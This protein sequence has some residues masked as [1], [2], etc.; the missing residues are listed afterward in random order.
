M[1]IYDFD[2]TIYR[3]DSTKDFYFHCLKRYPKILLSVPAMAWAFVLY[4]IGLKT[5][6]QFKE[7]MYRFLTYIDDVEAEVESFWDSHQDNLKNYYH[8]TKLADDIIIS[9]SP[10]FLLKP[11]ATRLNFGKLIAS[12]VDMHTGKY[13]GENCWGDEKV[14]RL[15]DELSISECETFYSD[16]LSDTPLA[17]IAKQAYI[18]KGEELVEWSKFE[19]DKTT[20]IKKMF[21]SK[22]FIMFLAVGG[23]N[24]INGVLFSMLYGML[25]PSPNLAF[26]VGYITSTVI[27]YLLNS[28]LTFKE[29]LGI[30]KYIK[31]FISYIPN[32][33]IQN[34][35]V[36]IVYN[37]LEFNELIA[38]I[39]AAVI[40]VPVTFVLM[41]IFAFRKKDG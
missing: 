15:Y 40:G 22:E 5:K 37:V 7:K 3:S 28:F 11:I 9:A 17:R 24:T 6:T 27:S 34:I 26:A 29:R 38:Y 41:K 16:S 35:V 1:N 32:F 10:E 30:V 13:T 25:I 4:F 36:F 31:F 33:I 18:V 21:F 19:N 2:K 14:K 20:K 8:T 39:L 23:I 12:R